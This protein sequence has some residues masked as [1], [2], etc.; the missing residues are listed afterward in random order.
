MT[1]DFIL[2]SCELKRRFVKDNNL[3]ITVY[4]EP[5]FT[6]RLII[7]DR[8]FDCVRKFELFCNELENFDN[9]QDYFARYNEIKDEVIEYLKA[10]D[11]FN[12][13]VNDNFFAKVQHNYPKNN[14]YS[15]AN[16]NKKFISIDMKK[17]N[18]SALRN[19]DPDIVDRKNAWEDFLREFTSIEHIL[20]SKYIRQVILGACNPKKQIQ[21]ETYLMHELMQFISHNVPD[22][23]VLSLGVDE[24]ILYYPNNV[25]SLEK[26]RWCVEHHVVGWMTRIEEFELLSLCNNGYVKRNIYN[27]DDVTFKCVDAETFHQYVKLFYGDEITENDKVFYHNGLL[28]KFLAPVDDYCFGVLNAE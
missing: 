4:H 24:I 20:N 28:A 18:F 17:A 3:P 14:L 1:K 6:E 9:E 13:F 27:A 10:K 15:P 11:E 7:L 2:N 25:E 21:Y 5:Y 26:I 22:V 16:L 23:E 8:M 12:V 19:Y